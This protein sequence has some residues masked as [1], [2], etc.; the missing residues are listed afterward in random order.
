MGQWLHTRCGVHGPPPGV[1]ELSLRGHGGDAFAQAPQ[2]MQEGP[3]DASGR[4]RLPQIGW[5]GFPVTDEG[6]G[7]L[8]RGPKHVGRGGGDRGHVMK[9]LWMTRGNLFTLT[10]RAES[11]SERELAPETVGPHAGP[12]LET[13]AGPGTP[14]ASS[15]PTGFARP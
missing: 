4:L 15:A 1:G 7:D 2:R 8:T 13:Q 10:V 14:L 5:V 9:C 3:K 11:G 12:H 6:R